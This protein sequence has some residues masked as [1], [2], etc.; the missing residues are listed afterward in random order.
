M[1]VAVLAVERGPDGVTHQAIL[2]ALRDLDVN[3]ASLQRDILRARSGL[4]RNYDPIVDAVVGLHDNADQLQSL[5]L[6]S[7]MDPSVFQSRLASLLKSIET[8]E[9]N[10]EEFKTRNAL[11]Q[12]S[13]GI[14]SEMLNSLYNSPYQETQRAIGSS[15]DLGNL[16]MQFS[17]RPTDELALLIR[18]HF[19]SLSTSSAQSVAEMRSLVTHGSIVLTTLPVVDES[20]LAIQTSDVP[21]QTR[22]LQQ[23]YL[24]AFGKLT[25]QASW[26]RVFLG[27][28]SIILCFGVALLIYRLRQ[29]AN[30]LTRQLEFE[31]VLSNAKNRL[32]IIHADD[33]TAAI[34]DATDSISIFFGS[35]EWTLAVMD[36]KK[37]TVKNRYSGERGTTPGFDS[38]SQSFLQ[39][40]RNP[41]DPTAGPRERFFI[42]QLSQ[43]LGSDGDRH[44]VAGG[45]IINPSAEDETALILVLR[46]DAHTP[47][48]GEEERVLFLSATE[49]L[50]QSLAI[51]DN[52]REKQALEAR[53]QHAQRLEAV[54]TLAGGIAH[55]FNN[56][57]GAILGY[58]EMALQRLHRPSAIRHYVEEIVSAGDRAKQV[59]DQILTFS[60]K[61]E[62]ISKPFDAVEAV[63]D[64]LPLLRVSMSED[65][66]IACELPDT[67]LVVQGNPIALQQITM[68]LCRNAREATGPGGRVEVRVHASKVASRK[69]LSHGEVEPGGY[70]V[71]SVSDN[72]IGIPKVILPHIFEPFFTTKT[73]SGGTGLGL[74][75]V[76][77]N[78]N[79]LQG[80]IDVRSDA[81]VGTCFD[82]Y[83]PVESSPAVPLAQFF[84]ESEL[85]LGQGQT[86]IILEK[87]RA[88]LLTYEEKLAALGYEAIGFNNV[89]SIVE[90]ITSSGPPDLLLLD[91][92]SLGDGITTSQLD[93]MFVHT[94]YILIT[95]QD[96][97]G[98]MSSARLKMSGALTKPLNSKSLASALYRNIDRRAN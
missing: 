51:A 87:D 93:K 80:Q 8:D 40:L 69:S 1:V 44:E 89:E 17:A 97:T 16:M 86:V 13:L 76:Y 58:G 71:L 98:L 96:R 2:T 11:L 19:T 67:E 10:V 3:H 36:W 50:A 28:V 15:N 35:T 31:G 43:G 37:G 66:D 88:L 25:E 14:F 30:R 39:H 24:R 21:L 26:S 33:F 54:G 29:H 72:G 65:Y 41:A 83:F 78:V 5:S 79:D 56:I 48:F 75:A 82:L 23:E 90:W 34:I 92:A 73:D 49:M 32:D 77:G 94:P 85:I 70:V 91:L 47:V 9:R 42:Q 20:V 84:T 22:N 53:L 45:A 57:L 18:H 4:L 12:N 46:R 7:G 55:E 61:R 52:R 60:R 95:D 64:I 38:L 27:T 6:L 68:N 74:A 62:P 63:G 59:V 81:S